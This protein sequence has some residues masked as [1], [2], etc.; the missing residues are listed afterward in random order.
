MTA[1][2]DLGHGHTLEFTCWDP[3]LRL[4]PQYEQFRHHL[5]VYPW[6]AIVE[7]L[8]PAG[9]VCRSAITFDDVMQRAMVPDSHR[10]EVESMV[11]LTL[12]P[13]L[14]CATCGDHGFVRNGQWVPA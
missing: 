12:S 7:H 1:P 9:E 5:P 8:T 2:L 3:D 4:N 6:G 10:W 13:S 14:L 11:P